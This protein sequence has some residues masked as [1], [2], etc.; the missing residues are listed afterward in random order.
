MR[1]PPVL[2]GTATR[3]SSKWLFLLPLDNRTPHVSKHLSC[4]GAEGKQ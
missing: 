3:R 2:R 4:G 1:L